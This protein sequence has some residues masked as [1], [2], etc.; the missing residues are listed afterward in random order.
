MASMPTVELNSEEAA[1][2]RSIRLNSIADRR[3]QLALYHLVLL[4]DDETGRMEIPGEL[5]DQIRWFAFNAGKAEWEQLLV[6]IFGRTLGPN[7][8]LGFFD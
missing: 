6:G 3:F 5:W 2:L 4:L 8:D 1:V 7:L